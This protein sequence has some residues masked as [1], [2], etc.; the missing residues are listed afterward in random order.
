MWFRRRRRQASLDLASLEQS[1]ERRTDRVEH[2]LSLLPDLAAARAPAWASPR[3]RNP[4]PEQE[5]EPEA[6]PEDVPEPVPEDGSIGHV[7]FV[8]RPDGYALLER[9]GA[10]PA[11]RDGVELDGERYVVLRNGPS[12]LP[13]DRR[14]CAFLEREEPRRAERTSAS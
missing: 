9:D 8:G 5:P 6:E 2:N 3:A 4:A 10:A 13:G 7:L 12:P 1:L 14:R 11:C